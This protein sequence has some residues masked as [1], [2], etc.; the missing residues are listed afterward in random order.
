MPVQ[1]VIYS[2]GVVTA[3]CLVMTFSS[4]VPTF[5]LVPTFCSV[6]TFCWFV[7]L[8]YASRYACQL[9]M[10]EYLKVSYA[11]FDRSA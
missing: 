10:D 7:G 1:E 9:V 6:Q 11:V 2:N 5:R 8:K 4:L 3:F